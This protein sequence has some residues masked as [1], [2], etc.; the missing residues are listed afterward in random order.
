M[1]LILHPV[2][3]GN[4]GI[5]QKSVAVQLKYDGALSMAGRNK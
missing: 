4:L 3:T 5:I 2:E 1:T